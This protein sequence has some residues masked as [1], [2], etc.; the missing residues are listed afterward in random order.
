MKRSTDRI[1]TT[2]AGSLPRP[3]DLRPMVAARAAGEPHDAVALAARLRSAVAE[4]VDLQIASGIDVVNDGELSKTSFSNYMRERLGGVEQ[5]PLPPDAPRSGVIFGRDLPEFSA[6]FAQRGAGVGGAPRAGGTGPTGADPMAVYCVG[7]ISYV[8]H[9]DLT[10]DIENFRAA[11]QGKQYEEAFLPAITPGTVEH[12]LINEH[13]PSAEAFLYAIADALHEEYKAIVDAGFI[14]QLDDPDM[15]DAW[16]IHPDL[17]VPD[18]RKFAELRLEALNYAIRDLPEE[19]VRFHMCW[20][21][22][23]GPHKYDIPLQD[24]VDLILKVNVQSYSIEASNPVHEHEWRVW[25]DVKIPDGR[26]LIPGV[27]G[28]FSDFVEHPRLVADRL[29]RYA[30]ILSRENVVAGTDCGLGTR[31]GHPNIC[32]AKF[33]A[34]ADGAQLATRELWG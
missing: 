30:R 3:D 2:H 9:N 7:P 34:M 22:Y 13:Y 32:W 24:I 31:V 8:G 21:S 27:V 11:L 19:R 5:R 33:R 28:H 25:E 14:L 12:W 26:F 1:L 17:T 23:H 15:A 10:T 29:D 6:Y 20:G 4:V 18:Y 16:Q